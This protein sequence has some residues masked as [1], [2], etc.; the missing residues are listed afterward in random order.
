M[1]G[2]QLD[3]RRRRTIR[4]AISIAAASLVV[5]GLPGQVGATRNA[6]PRRP[7]VRAGFPSSGPGLLGHD[8]RWLT[9]A[10]GRVVLLHG[11]N[12]VAKGQETPAERG[13]GDDDAQW[14]QDHGF[15]VVRLGLSPDAF[16]QTP[17]VVSSAYLTSF[18]QTVQTLTDHGLLVLVDLH[19][20]GWGPVT[21]GNGFPAWMTFTHGA[22]N[23]HTGFPLYYVTNPAIQAAFDSLWANEQADGVGLEDHIAT[24]FSA[25]AGAVGSNPNVI[26]YDILN[27]PWPGTNWNPCYQGDGCPAQDASGLDQLHDKVTTAIRAKDA[28]HLVFG[29]PY[30]LFNFGTAPTHISLPGGDP[31]SGMSW[32]MYTTAP[33]YEPNVIANAIAWSEQ[34]GGAL[35]NSE[36]DEAKTLGDVNRMVG[37]LDNGLIPWIWWA[38]DGF[39]HNM[40]DPLTDAN[41][42]QPTADALVRPHPVQVAGTPAALDYDEAAKVL[43]FRYSTTA[44][45]GKGL[46]DGTE[47]VIK[48]PASSLPDGYELQVTGGTV[49]SAPDAEVLTIVA[50]GSAG[51]VF[52]KLWAKGDPEPDD[53]FP[54]SPL[55]KATSTTTTTAP[56]GSTTATAPGGATEAPGATPVPGTSTYT[57]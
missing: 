39:V 23:T 6:P 46:P 49:T 22:E 17:G 53:A 55:D 27:E 29:E 30:V 26:G 28:D 21:S 56:T 10:Q 8:G 37:E 31:N 50:D 20:D 15:D 4:N 19:Q 42:D 57:G 43:R 35:L 51:S 25:L 18:A 9:D 44:P 2:N 16:M 1:R 34:T 13:F 12:L 47:T 48:V 52:V 14:L 32:H 3:G 40:T 38:Y 33:S 54:P 24:M 5:L 11:V 45:N 7:A 36:F 41:I